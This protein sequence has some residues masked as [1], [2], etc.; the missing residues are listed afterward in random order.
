VPVI[1][2]KQEISSG[3]FEAIGGEEVGVGR[4]DAVP[5]EI[6]SGLVRSGLLREI[7]DAIRI[8]D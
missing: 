5:S 2:V 8:V 4:G 6:P 3:L 1:V 7:F